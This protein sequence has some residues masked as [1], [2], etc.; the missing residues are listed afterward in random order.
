M[1]LIDCV[2]KY[3]EL[4]YSELKLVVVDRLVL[5]VLKWCVTFIFGQIAA[6]TL[7]F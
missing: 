1:R 6:S 7:A 5:M 2:H 4:F 3:V